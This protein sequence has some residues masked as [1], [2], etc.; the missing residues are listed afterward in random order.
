MPSP[1]TKLH[2]TPYPTPYL[3]QP[4][5]QSSAYK[6]QYHEV[7]PCYL[8]KEQTVPVPDLYAYDGVPQGQPQPVIGSH[9]LLGLRDD[10]CF[11]RFGRYGPYGLGYSC[12]EGGLGVGMDTEHED[13]QAVWAKTGKINYNG[14]DWGD[15]QTRCYE[16]NKERFF[17]AGDGSGSGDL[18][19]L[20][21]TAV[22]VRTYIGVDW[23]PHVILNFRALISE[24]AL[25]SGAEYDV[26][27]LLHVR[28]D[29]RPIWADGDVARQVLDEY[30]P[31][32]FHNICT[33]WSEAQMRLL[34]PGTFGKSFSDPSNA[35]IHGVY[36]SAH[37]PL[38]D[39][40]M[41]H[42]EYE[43]FWNWEMDMRF[44]GNYYE[45]FDRL[46][47]WGREQT[48][49]EMWERA[50]KYYI[51]HLHGS[52]DNFT[53]AVHVETLAGGRGS[54]LGPVN[55]P[56][57]SPTRTEQ[58]SESFVPDTCYRARTSSEMWQDC[59]V[60]EEADL[61]TLNPLFDTEDSGWVFDKD[62][63]G[64]DLSQPVPP[65]RSSIVTASRLSWRLLEVMHE[66]TWRMRHTMFSEMFPATMALHHGLKAVYAPH[67]VYLDREWDIGAID[68]A[69]NGGRDHSTS[70]DGSPFG[71]GNE[72][73]HK[74]ATWYYN[75]EF[76]GL[77][78]RRWLGYP[79]MDARGENG[80][81]FGSGTLRGGR[82]EEEDR[83][84]GTGRLCL[85]SM[86]V[87][88]IKWENPEELG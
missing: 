34:Y 54:I 40:A 27:F 2:R 12:S 60:G 85:R 56:G 36:R 73:N 41:K 83:N 9:A 24:L 72:H 10:I 22:V 17:G 31:A 42:P 26:H 74:G 65:R 25:R 23:T 58:R 75:S 7:N 61:I 84:K 46:G 47:A 14:V 71:L 8:D 59:G 78:W 33:L 13:S 3:P 62:V 39:F 43:H 15:A 28:D 45:L 64:Y 35:D 51:P 32:E 70:G 50:S 21:R 5:Y 86:L 66:E 49:M 55:F 6:S 52:W 19:K 11:D 44:L 82:R 63:T 4:D 81:S 37:M 77:L 1:P 16:S 76:A 29:D 30:V 87:H 18:A 69:F 68:Q 57:R 79:Q 88:P 20:P 48:R 80:G 67:P 38:Q 53:R